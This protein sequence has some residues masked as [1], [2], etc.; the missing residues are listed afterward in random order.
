M[1]IIS[2]ACWL[3]LS[4]GIIISDAHAGV[5]GSVGGIVRNLN[6]DNFTDM[7]ALNPN[8]DTVSILLGSGPSIFDQAVEYA[9]GSHPQALVVADF[10]QDGKL[11][12]A[13]TNGSPNS[14]NG[15]SVSIL[16]GNGDGTFQ[17][18]T[19]YS[20]GSNPYGI[21]IGDFDRDGNVD[22]AVV[23]TSSNTVSILLSNGDG[24][25]QTKVDY[26]TGQNTYGIEIGQYNQ[27]NYVDLEIL[28]SAGN[29]VTT[30]YGVGDGT[31]DSGENKM[32]LNT[33]TKI[34]TYRK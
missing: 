20:V 12:L 16:L 5:G 21:A 29:I 2:T 26:S 15:G 7:I 14:Q 23:N 27:D 24:T 8:H 19:D 17:S 25:F 30:L 13:I 31:F 9:T 6:N 34:H 33:G 28:D 1:R 32:M 3:V 22:L 11:D 18:K 4:V 10:D